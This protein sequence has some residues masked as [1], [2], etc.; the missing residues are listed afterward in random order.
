[1]TIKIYDMVGK[2]HEL[3]QIDSYEVLE[4]SIIFKDYLGKVV[5]IFLKDKIIGM[6]ITR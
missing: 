6:Q 2:I 5:G 3:Y 4:D 1:M